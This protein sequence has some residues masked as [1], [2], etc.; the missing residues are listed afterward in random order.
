MVAHGALH[1]VVAVSAGKL[2]ENYI[3]E[4]LS[5]WNKTDYWH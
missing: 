2:Q 1:V 4:T 5:N 3:N